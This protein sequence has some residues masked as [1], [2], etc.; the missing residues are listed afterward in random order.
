MKHLYFIR[1]GESVMNT[2]GLSSGHTDTPLTQTGIDQ[3][4]NAGKNAKNQGL[5][6]DAI[7][8]SPLQRAHHTAQHVASCID[9]PL[10]L[11]ELH[12]NLKERDFG[13]L[14]GKNMT[15]DYGIDL[16]YYYE[17][18][19]S[20]DHIKNVETIQQ[21]HKRAEEVYKYLKS[22][23]E[24]NILV[25]GHGAFLRSLQRVIDGLPYDAPVKPYDNAQ[26]VKLI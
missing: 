13:D 25:V 22:R 24:D 2:Q 4:K 3:A 6:F 14:E 10:E 8:S 18:P 9:H 20:V 15:K 1:H 17:N 26:V 21:L 16:S 23:P 5:K 7:I 12:E 19:T 11:I